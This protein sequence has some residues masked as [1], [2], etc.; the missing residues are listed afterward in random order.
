MKILVARFWVRSNLLSIR[1]EILTS[2]N[3]QVG[4]TCHSFFFG[5]ALALSFRR[6]HRALRRREGAKTQSIQPMALLL[7]R[8]CPRKSPTSLSSTD[9]P[10]FPSLPFSFIPSFRSTQSFPI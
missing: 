8:L 4:V 10:R 1:F 7:F 2:Q 9:F 5:V 6:E 3:N